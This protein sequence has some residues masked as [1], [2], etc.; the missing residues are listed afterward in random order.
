MEFF[1]LGFISLDYYKAMS[2]RESHLGSGRPTVF[3]GLGLVGVRRRP[4]D[5][6][7]GKLAKGEA[8]KFKVNV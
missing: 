2:T 4:A 3:Y 1:E 8:A 7:G 6:L 5:V